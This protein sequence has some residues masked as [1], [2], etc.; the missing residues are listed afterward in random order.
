MES[1]RR[2]LT[3]EE[4]SRYREQEYQQLVKAFA[5]DLL[6]TASGYP[7]QINF[8]RLFATLESFKNR[9]LKGDIIAEIKKQEASPDVIHA[10]VTLLNL[11]DKMSL[12]TD[13]QKHYQFIVEA[14]ADENI[15]L[16]CLDHIFLHFSTHMYVYLHELPYDSSTI[17]KLLFKGDHPA[18]WLTMVEKLQEIGERKLTSKL[19]TIYNH[20][21]QIACLERAEM[22]TLFK[23]AT[24]N[25]AIGSLFSRK[26]SLSTIHDMKQKILAE[27]TELNRNK[28]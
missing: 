4:M 1:T 15:S 28:I 27:Q 25:Y 17:Q 13:T 20:P 22:L 6:S 16:R 14:M 8:T 10:A 3:P 7:F 2:L 18:A 26:S 21:E 11:R 19:S 23:A 24:Y 12:E 9:D 5:N